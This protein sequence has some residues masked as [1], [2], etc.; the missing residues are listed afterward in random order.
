L[1]KKNLFLK[2]YK[3]LN[4]VVSGTTGFKGAWLAFWLNS[5][6]ARVTGI[7]LRPEKDSILFKS[8]NLINKID[9]HF[10]DINN[11]T[12]VNDLIKKTKPDIIFHL[13]AQSI[14]SQS[15]EN[16]LN[17]F[18]TNILG[19]ANILEAYRVNKIPHLVYITSDK[20][21]LNLDLKKNYKEKDILGGLDNYSSSKASA[22][23]IFYSYAQSYFKKDNYLKTA[24]A[25]AGN[26]IGG[27]DMKAKRILPDI[28]K[29]LEKGHNLLLRHPKAT[30]PWQHVLE[31]LSG[32]LLIGHKLLNQN[33]K[34]NIYPSWNFGPETKNCK[35]VEYISK[36]ALRCWG[37][38]STKIKL[39]QSK[40]YHESKFLSL[41]INKAQKELNWSPR[42]NL[43][44]TINLTINWYK[45]YFRKE[46]M[47]KK[48]DNQI[49]FFLDK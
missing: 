35:S 4:V 38:N 20:C 48:T 15:F 19:S 39:N 30:R 24:S 44:Q 27:G 22:E 23:L 47:K 28:I 11:F 26:V 3:K 46:D 14:V 32:Y 29:S 7:A 16:P 17:T 13:A 37:Q 10:I 21:Y 36:L 5:L 43:N 9:Q 31:P 18:K 25:R 8:L 12:K 42:L 34:K 2:S 49:Q 6:G 40:Q 45:S 41:N 33:L 1:K